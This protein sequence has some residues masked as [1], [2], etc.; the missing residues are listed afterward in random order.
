MISLWPFRLRCRQ[1]I[2]K[3]LPVSYRPALDFPRCL[4]FPRL[5]ADG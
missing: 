1:A 2:S 4:D 5:V 3:V